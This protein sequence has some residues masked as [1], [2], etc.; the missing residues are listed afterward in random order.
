ML[1]PLLLIKQQHLLPSQCCNFSSSCKPICCNLSS[2]LNALQRLQKRRWSLVL[3]SHSIISNPFV[4]TFVKFIIMV[5]ALLK[6]RNLSFET[7]CRS[8]SLFTHHVNAIHS[9]WWALYKTLYV[10][11][12]HNWLDI[13]LWL[14]SFE[15]WIGPNVHKFGKL[16]NNYDTQQHKLWKIAASSNRVQ[17][18]EK[19]QYQEVKQTYDIA[20]DILKKHDQ[21]MISFWNGNPCP[22]QWLHN[23]HRLECWPQNGDPWPLPY[24]LPHQAAPAHLASYT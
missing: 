19:S 10:S 20:T 1:K 15:C 4:L 24:S 2:P 17:L 5:S 23:S 13:Y 8:S 9:D 21:E 7:S 12:S 6:S 16:S 11:L 22:R 18:W 3:C 14:W